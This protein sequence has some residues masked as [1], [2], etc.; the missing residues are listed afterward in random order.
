[1][2][3]AVRVVV[4]RAIRRLAEAGT[5]GGTTRPGMRMSSM[6]ELQDEYRSGIR[7]PLPP[8]ASSVSDHHEC[9]WCRSLGSPHG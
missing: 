7:L 8:P 9:P 6:P 4:M 3:R 2:A 1:M 5:A